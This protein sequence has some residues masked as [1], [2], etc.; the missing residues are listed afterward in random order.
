VPEATF[1]IIAPKGPRLPVVAHMPHASVRIPA[2]VKAE[3]LIDEDDLKAELVRL[4]DWY[5]DDLFAPLADHGATLFV[6][7]LSRFVFD[8]E[9]FLDESAEPTAAR[10]QGV[11]YTHGTQGQRLR[12]LPPGLRERR[13]EELYRPYH[14][15]L[16]AVVA[17]QLSEFGEATVIDCHS[18]PSLPLPS[19]IDQ[20]ADRPDICIGTDTVHTPPELAEA[21][22]DAFTAEGFRVG[23]NSPF[24]GTFVPSGFYG[25]DGRVRS[26]MIE[27]RR[28]L[29]IDEATAERLPDF[30]DAKLAIVRALAA[31]GALGNQSGSGED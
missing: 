12:E 18:F 24:A 3:I 9:R 15:A 21:V 25:R 23:R 31:S 30:D 6:N 13:I 27:V 2:S 28:G 16:D 19:E 7:R 1:E 10:G 26:L 5:T 22:M 20:T 8:P 29:Y 11:V 4:T 17:A 14:A